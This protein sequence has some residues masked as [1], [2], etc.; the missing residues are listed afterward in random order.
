M[1]FSPT[2]THD[3]NSLPGVQFTL[4]R[5]G[6]G[7]RVDLDQKTLSLRQ[8][9]REIEADL[10]LPNDQERL[11]S[12]QLEIAKK[13]AA[14]VPAEE[15]LDVLHKDVLPLAGE[16]AAAGDPATRRKRASMNEEYSTVEAQVRIFW[17]RA[18]LISI[19]GGQVEGL[20]ADQLLEYGP[21]VLAG[22]IY[23]ALAS[24]GA[25]RGQSAGN[26]QSPTTSGAP[27]GGETATTIAPS[28]EP[29]PT[30]TT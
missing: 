15:L 10:P 28:A 21:P 25:L 8:R 9:L 20:T 6:Y 2:V 23:D 19:E 4:H 30:A 11:L 12:E 27:V 22:E 17:I 14:A 7:R 26:W 24:E 29:Q 13:K 5:M 3:S 1:P 18:G 16:L